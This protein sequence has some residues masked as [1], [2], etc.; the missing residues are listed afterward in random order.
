MFNLIEFQK[1]QINNQRLKELAGTGSSL[2]KHIAE[3][4]N[5][6]C[7]HGLVMHFGKTTWDNP[8]DGYGVCICCGKKFLLNNEEERKQYPDHVLN[9]SW[10]VS[11]DNLYAINEFGEEIMVAKAREILLN[12][13]KTENEIQY[14]KLQ[15]YLADILIGYDKELK[16]KPERK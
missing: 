16:S 6:T 11:L 3:A 5:K 4:Y 7:N 9:I 8:N 13:S 1:R 10:D 15:L 12:L 14:G 2:Y